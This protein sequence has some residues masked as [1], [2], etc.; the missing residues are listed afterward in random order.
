MFLYAI[1]KL[2]K[3]VHSYTGKTVHFYI[4]IN[5][6]FHKGLYTSTMIPQSKCFEET[7]LNFCIVSTS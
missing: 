3:I 2:N 1:R 6:I 5:S 7:K 4:D